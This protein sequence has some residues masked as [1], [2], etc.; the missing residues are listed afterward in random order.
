M[1]T[2]NICY[3][4]TVCCTHNAY[5]ALQIV[6]P[7]VISISYWV[8]VEDTV[9]IRHGPIATWSL[10]IKDRQANSVLV[11]PPL[12][13]KSAHQCV[14]RVYICA[15]SAGPSAYFVCTNTISAQH[16]NFQCYSSDEVITDHSNV[17]CS[18]EL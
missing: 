12:C 1:K 17:I 16:F 7:T 14:P 2:V 5:L 8:Y 10:K 18:W 13:P 3:D 11:Y 4:S 6:K 15:R 9:H